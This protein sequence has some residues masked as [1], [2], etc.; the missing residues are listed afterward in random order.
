MGFFNLG[1][2]ETFRNTFL[3]GG[4]ISGALEIDPF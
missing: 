4:D 2:Q 3:K 1:E